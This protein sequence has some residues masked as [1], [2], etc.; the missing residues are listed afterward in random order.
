M[1]LEVK[2]NVD[3]FKESRESL[4]TRGRCCLRS[5]RHRGGRRNVALAPRPRLLD[6]AHLEM[7]QD[8]RGEVEICGRNRVDRQRLHCL[9]GPSAVSIS[10][11]MTSP[12]LILSTTRINV[13]KGCCN[14]SGISLHRISR[15]RTTKTWKMKLYLNIVLLVVLSALA[16]AVS[17]Q[18][19]V[20]VSYPEDTPQSVL[21]Q[22]MAAIKKAVCTRY[23]AYR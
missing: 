7:M 21:E 15:Y 10:R 19:P 17:P 14:V 3:G 1:R 11:Q 5:R 13:H 23:L 8:G 20:I 18:K 9:T 6:Y 4:R 12:S 22:A 16:G 2:T